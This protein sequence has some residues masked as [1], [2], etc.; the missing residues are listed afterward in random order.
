MDLKSGN[1]WWHAVTW[2]MT[3]DVLPF[4]ENWVDSILPCS[5]WLFVASGFYWNF[6]YS[7]P[8]MVFNILSEIRFTYQGITKFCMWSYIISSIYRYCCVS[9]SSVPLINCSSAAI[10]LFGH[11]PSLLWRYK[12]ESETVLFSRFFSVFRCKKREVT[13]VVMMLGAVQKFHW[14]VSTGETPRLKQPV[15]R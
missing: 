7:F 3:A 1:C 11:Y 12:G 4:A 13:T 2:A 15:G 14:A 5:W 9:Y 10:F 6:L 8:Q